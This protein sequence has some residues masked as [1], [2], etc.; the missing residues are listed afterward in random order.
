MRLYVDVRHDLRRV[1]ESAHSGKHAEDIVG[2]GEDQAVGQV[3]LD[4]RDRGILGKNV[5]ERVTVGGNRSA[6]RC[7]GQSGVIDPVMVG[8]VVVCEWLCVSGWWRCGFGRKKVFV[9]SSVP[10]KVARSA[11]LNHLR[12]TQRKRVGVHARNRLC[13]HVLVRL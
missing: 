3:A 1:R 8:V 11:R 9:S 2:L 12:R 13:L 5:R 7:Q 6:L 4:V 10:A